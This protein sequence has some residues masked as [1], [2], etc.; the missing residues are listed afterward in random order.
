MHLV[1]AGKVYPGIW[2]KIDAA[3][4]EISCPEWCFIP[5]EQV[6]RIIYP[7]FKGRTNLPALGMDAARL[8]GLAAWRVTQGIYRFDPELY[9][10][11]VTTCITR[12][13]MEILTLMPAWGIY[14]ETSHNSD[15]GF[16]AY[17]E[18]DHHA[19]LAELRLLIDSGDDLTPF[20]IPLKNGTLKD[21]VNL[22]VPERALFGSQRSL[23]NEIE[24]LVSLVLYICS[25]AADFGHY[26]VKRPGPVK[27][28]RGL[29]FFPASKPTVI[30][31]GEN[32]GAALRA[33]R[34]S[35]VREISSPS[36]RATRPHVRRAHWHGYW[37]GKP[38]RFELRWMPPILVKCE[39]ARCA[40][41]EV[42]PDKKEKTSS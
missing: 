34:G 16:F 18:W 5:V 14:V 8:A 9:N 31:T 33:S 21:A 13:P 2:Q 42:I 17:C 22:I 25:V 6:I 38:E 30:H 37:M 28:K 27:T 4:N 3:R 36:G 39:Q 23:I 41:H 32:I 11:L 26:A 24:P 1:G 40:I 10:A 19:H 35:A 29:R 12:L 15:K 20:A 7:E